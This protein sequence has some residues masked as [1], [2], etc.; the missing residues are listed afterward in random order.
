MRLW[1]MNV[2]EALLREQV[3]FKQG[4]RLGVTGDLLG[5]TWE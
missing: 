3:N 5:C 4:R 1:E 2:K